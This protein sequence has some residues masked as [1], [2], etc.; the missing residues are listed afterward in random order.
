MKYEWTKE[1]VLDLFVTPRTVGPFVIGATLLLTGWA[2]GS[3]WFSG[4]GLV[5]LALGGVLGLTRLVTD[6]ETVYLNQLERDRK[7]RDKEAEDR[8]AKTWAVIRLDTDRRT[9]DCLGE[10]VALRNAF[11]ESAAGESDIPTYFRETFEQLFWQSLSQIEKSHGLYETS[12]KLKDKKAVLAKRKELVDEVVSSVETLRATYEKLTTM[13]TT[14]DEEGLS[15]LREDL[16]S[17]LTV[18]EAVGQELDGVRRHDPR[19]D[20]YLK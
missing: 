16:V 14:R 3:A 7:R 18:A 5:A 10:L 11:Q 19:M 9:R 2:V 8:V 12:K 13:A 1:F 17:K 4:T 15:R 20:E 6:A